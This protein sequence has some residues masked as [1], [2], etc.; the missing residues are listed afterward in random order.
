[1]ERTIFE[2]EHLHFRDAVRR[3]VEKEVVPNRE[4]WEAQ[5]RVDRSLFT[6]AGQAGLLGIA[7]PEAHGGGGMTDFRYNAI[8]SECLAEADVL[9]AGL[10]LSL[11]AD[12][13]L[14]YLLHLATEEQQ[15]RWLPGA[16]SGETIL[17]LAMSEPG[18]GSDV[19][20]I[21][22]T[23]R[24]D[25]DHYV[26]DG[27]KT[28]ITNGQNADLIITAVKTDPSERHKG[29]SLLVIEADRDGFSR[30][31]KLAK[32]G[33]HA[34]DTS[35]LFFDGVRV[36]VDNRLGEEGTGF[37]AMMGNLA[38]E[39]LSIAVQAVAQAERSV[40]TS[41]E[42]ATQ[43]QAFGSPIGSFQHIRFTLAELQTQVDVART[44]V[45]RLLMDFVEGRLSDVD[46][47]KAKWW[48]TE[49]CQQIVDKCVQVHGGY[50]YMAEYPV[51]R[52]WVDSRI[53][54]IYG[55]TT[56]IMKEIIGRS[57]GL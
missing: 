56:E 23:A 30:G 10:G 39:R 37:Y 28:F 16:I 35:E 13:A 7:A 24:L 22:T 50:G 2:E 47:A 25:G 26:V 18:A 38:Q 53:Q 44:Y 32:V 40:A 43:R 11:Q 46:A 5:G 12:I 6:A 8:I 34:A 27:A 4:A 31:R 19:A 14:P 9:S 49:L 41:V 3:F 33:Q 15:A 42:Y 17:A 48:T 21:A 29:I 45:D 1:M 51:A 54:T 20:G 36:P 57:M 52:A 55:G